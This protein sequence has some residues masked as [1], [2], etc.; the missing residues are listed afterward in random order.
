MVGQTISHYRIINELGRGGMGIVYRAEDEKLRRTVAIKVLPSAMLASDD[1]RSRFYREARAAAALS[2]PNIATVYAI[3]EAVPDGSGDDDVRPFIAMEF[4][5]G[6][7]LAKRIE[8]GPFGLEEAINVSI[9]LAS[10][11]QAAHDNNIVHRDVKSAN[12]MLTKRGSAKVLDF[13]LA[14]TVQSTKL[15]TMGSTL[16]TVAYMSPEQARG[17]EVDARTD[18]W[19]LGVVLYEMI[20]GRLPFPGDYEQAVVFEI[21]NQD[22]KPLTAIR[23]GVPIELEMIVAKLLAK[24][25]E[26]RYQGAP[27]VIADL[28]R[29]DLSSRPASGISQ[30]SVASATSS[31]NDDNRTQ[32]AA[33]FRPIHIAA[34]VGGLLLGAAG[35]WA[36]FDRPDRDGE[37][38]APVFLD[39]NLPDSM[40]FD[41][42]HWSKD[43][44]RILFS[45]STETRVGFIVEYNLRSGILTSLTE[46]DGNIYPKYSPDGESIYFT[47]SGR[48]L[49]RQEIGSRQASFVTAVR[50]LDEIA[51]ISQDEFVFAR[52]REVWV[53]NETT[54]LEDTLHPGLPAVWFHHPIVSPDSRVLLFADFGNTIAFDLESKT[55]IET[56]ETKDSPIGAM[57]SGHFVY[58]DLSS[59]YQVATRKIDFSA[60]IYDGQ[61][62]GHFQTEGYRIA[63]SWN[64][65]LIYQPRADPDA[66][67]WQEPI[68][69]YTLGMSPDFVSA[70]G[71][72]TE[73]HHD[74]FRISPDGRFLALWTSDGLVRFDRSSRTSTVLVDYDGRP[75]PGE[76]SRDGVWI[77]FDQESDGNQSI[78]RVPSSGQAEPEPVIA[79]PVNEKNPS[80]STDGGVVIF[81]REHERNGYDIWS[82]DLNT[83]RE[84]AIVTASG[85][86]RYPRISPDSRHIAF[87][88]E[89]REGWSVLLTDIEGSNSAIVAENAWKPRWSLDGDYLFYET[90][91]PPGVYRVRLLRNPL[92]SS[93]DGPAF[94]EPEVMFSEPRAHHIHWDVSPKDD[95][96]LLSWPGQQLE[97]GSQ[98][99]VV[100]NWASTL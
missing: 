89:G 39:L 52:N 81:E 60:R 90:P 84:T 68:F 46:A 61:G 24:D 79:G 62:T 20:S 59:Y 6:P 49:M 12:V 36:A 32:V 64:G 87:A 40:V 94:G 19:S 92:D 17:E 23:T 33:T 31:P 91:S 98:W 53:R 48:S 42:P 73:G 69:E 83:G 71:T 30:S 21:L 8:E 75:Y 44:T 1:D 13:G 66:P 55:R 15:T 78:F 95:T 57:S 35:M 76:W 77:Y 70:A 26:L 2:H 3:D 85:N 10:A 37:E 45:A 65:H 96:I 86:Q 43:G 11:L 28:K 56:L 25:R 16:G 22:P 51:W 29:I 7:S 67:S 38:A 72:Y 58:R 93:A 34:L 74:E 4:I 88:S 5:D 41:D 14:K 100:L 27:D 9:Q 99:K 18:L 54:G 47:Q 80:V 82:L 63:V 50:G 97:G